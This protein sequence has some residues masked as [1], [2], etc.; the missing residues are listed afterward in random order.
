MPSQETRDDLIDKLYNLKQNNK[1]VVEYVNELDNLVY[2]L[3]TNYLEIISDWD[4]WYI[5]VQGVHPQYT[6]ILATLTIDEYDL[7]ADIAIEL[8]KGTS[9][10]VIVDLF[11]L[12]GE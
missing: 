6:A 8:E 4:L 10:Q 12:D 5:F 3:S 2:I 9:I 1:T 11:N 7:A